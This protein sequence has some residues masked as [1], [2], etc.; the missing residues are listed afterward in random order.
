[1]FILI[2]SSKQGILGDVIVEDVV[3][4]VHDGDSIKPGKIFV[5]VLGFDAPEVIS[6]H[7]SANQPQGVEAGKFARALLKGQSVKTAYWGKDT[8]KRPLVKIQFGGEDFAE[9]MLLK[10]F[11]WY[12]YSPTKLTEAERT[13]YKAAV[14]AA[15]K[16]EIGIWSE[17]NPIKPSAWRAAH[18]Y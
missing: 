7:V 14:K 4:A 17:P 1:M 12:T 11:G 2:D 3:M 6:N 18:R 13:A 9:I 10:G 8:Y 5:R 16:A 15:K